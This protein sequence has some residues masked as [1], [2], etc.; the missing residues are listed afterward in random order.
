M[1]HMAVAAKAV[2]LAGFL[3]LWAAAAPEGRI[4]F[5]NA[6]TVPAVAT[7]SALVIGRA[8]TPPALDGVIDAAEWAAAGTGGFAFN[9]DDSKRTTVH[10]LYDAEAL[11]LAF[12][13]AEP[14]PERIRAAS[15]PRKGGKYG[16]DAGGD[17]ELTY[18]DDSVEVF[19]SPDARQKVLYQ[20]IA[21][22]GG[23]RLDIRYDLPAADAKYSSG[24][25]SAAR[26]E[27]DGWCVELAIPLKAI[28]IDAVAP[29]KTALRINF[30]RNRVVDGHETAAWQPFWAWRGAMPQGMFAP[31]CDAAVG[32]VR[33]G[34]RFLGGNEATLELRGTGGKSAKVRLA[35]VVTQGG[36][37]VTRQG[38]A[39]EVK[40]G[41]SA[42]LAA[43]YVIARPDAPV[44]LVLRV[45]GLDGAAEIE[46]RGLMPQRPVEARLERGGYGRVD[47]PACVLFQL[48][49]AEGSFK[50]YRLQASLA[51]GGQ[52]AA[53]VESELKSSSGEAQFVLDAREAREYE[54]SATLLDAKGQALFRQPVGKLSWSGRG[55]EGKAAAGKIALRLDVPASARGET[56]RWPVTVGVPFAR[57]DLASA[58]N[59]RLLGPDGKET[60]IEVG[61]PA[62]WDRARSSI[63]WLHVRCLVALE[64]AGKDYTLEYGPQVRRAATTS[65]LKAAQTEESVV[66]DTG[67]LKFSVARRPFRFIDAAWLDR[68]GDGQYAEEER[69]ISSGPES[70]LLVETADGRRYRSDATLDWPEV[71]RVELESA[72]PM[73]AVI[74]AEGWH[75]AAPHGGNPQRMMKYVVRIVATADTALLR[76]FHSFIL[77]ENEE[78]QYRQVKLGFHLPEGETAVADHQSR[79][80]EAIPPGG[81]AALAQVNHDAYRLQLRSPERGPS[82]V[83]MQIGEKS[84]G[85]LL[86]QRKGWGLTLATRDFWQNYAKGY[87][88]RRDAVALCPWPKESLQPLSF[89][90]EEV[91]APIFVEQLAYI[92]NGLRIGDGGNYTTYTYGVGTKPLGASKTHEYLLEFTPTPSPARSRLAQRLLNDPP[93]LV[94][95]PAYACAT[96]VLGRIAP[97]NKEA[98]PVE[99]AGFK[100]MLGRLEYGK[101]EHRFYGLINFGESYQQTGNTGDISVYRT[102][103][104]A[105][106]GIVNDLYRGYFRSGDREWFRYAVRR[107]RHGRDLDHCHYGPKAGGQ[108]EYDTLH[109]GTA[110]EPITFW[111][112]RLFLLQDWYMTGDRRSWDTFLLACDAVARTNPGSGPKDDRHWFNQPKELVLMYEATWEPRFLEMAKAVV[113]G[114][115]LAKEQAG[116]G[117]WPP[118]VT[119]KDE[120]VQP[121]LLA[122]HQFTKDPRVLEYLKALLRHEKGVQRY[123]TGLGQDLAAY[124]YWQTGEVS[125]LELVGGYE[126]VRDYMR[127]FETGVPPPVGGL[128]RKTVSEAVDGWMKTWGVKQ[129]TVFHDGFID[130]G[131]HHTWERLW[132]FMAALDDARAKGTLKAYQGPNNPWSEPAWD[133][134]YWKTVPPEKAKEWGWK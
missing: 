12:R 51:E 71:E 62:T 104:N 127:L 38:A 114:V 122:Y 15:G 75:K 1:R 76:V 131:F 110:Y 134:E 105:G 82:I 115:L 2:L 9:G 63:R 37:R 53:S 108:T 98:Y 97:F 113:D 61:I 19:I 67:R 133:A 34:K 16:P 35:T 56:G 27:G 95:P 77:T 44:D 60:P 58:D 29:G 7:D 118:E 59:V 17:C 49:L 31:K 66:V 41:A 132:Y 46:E 10:A 14:T 47:G 116:A 50:E 87:E 94:V 69:V 129:K 24:F 13:C 117:K 73:E 3:S 25:R 124:L 120:Y 130:K 78:V 85:W 90:P 42:V 128:R 54:A 125:W 40:A 23:A 11:Y 72:G 21:N 36:E 111:T 84:E 92:S 89:R 86:V 99:E 107:T 20:F 32:A 100:A 43:P 103:Q 57:G 88:V 119:A 64:D 83:A 101:A 4:L 48:N 74:R 22:S 8:T 68:N 112:H 106:Y 5:S 123:A 52:P 121:S 70:G 55:E 30:G 81:E 45:E 102:F 65:R 6:P 39:V 109:W 79:A 126:A 96:E 18:E 33:Y 93:L 28:G 80:P 91:V 26:V